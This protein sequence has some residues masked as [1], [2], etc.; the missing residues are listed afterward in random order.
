MTENNFFLDL[1]EDY[2]RILKLEDDIRMRVAAKESIRME[3]NDIIQVTS[4]VYYI[5]ELKNNLLSIKKLQ[6]KRL[7]IMIRDGT[8]TISS[9]DGG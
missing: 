2:C 6:E 5:H 3:L 1:E 7:V 4:D 9:Y 8:C